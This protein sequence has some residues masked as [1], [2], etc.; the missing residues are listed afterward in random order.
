MSVGTEAS[1]SATLLDL[2]ET[3]AGQ[4]GNK[5][6]LRFLANGEDEQS[7]LTYA[8][9]DLR[10]RGFASRLVAFAAP[11]DRAVLVYPPGVEFLVAFFGCVYAGVIAVPVA[12]PFDGA[13]SARLFTVVRDS[14]P[15]CVLVD[16]A[17][18]ALVRAAAEGTDWLVASIDEGLEAGAA[19][20][21]RPSTRADHV[22]MLQYTSGSTRMPRGVMVTHANLLSNLAWLKAAMRLPT[23]PTIVSWLPAFHDMG[24]IGSLFQTLYNG[25]DCVLMSPLD[26]LA[27][28]LVWLR[29]IS[30][31][32]A[33]A[34]GSP[35][36]GY[37]LAARKVTADQ[38]DELDLRAWQMACVTAE[39]IR[40]AG[41]TRF[42][43]AF[44]PCGF[45]RESFYPCY[46]L[47]E[48]TLMVTGAEARTVPQELVVRESKLQLGVAAPCGAS[49]ADT[50]SLVA[51]GTARPG[52]RVAIVDPDTG[53]ERAAGH[54]GEIW[55]NG[56]NVARGYWG[57][58][59]ETR[60][61][62]EAHLEGDAGPFLRTGDLGFLRDG[63][64]YVTGRL[65][66]VLI[67]R[68]RNLYPHDIEWTAQAADPRVRAGCGAAFTVGEPDDPVIVLV[69]EISDATAAD[70]LADVVRRGVAEK[71]GHAVHL[72]L[73]Q[74]RTIPK[75]SSGKVQHSRCRQMYLDGELAVIWSPEA[76][77]AGNRPGTVPTMVT[78]EPDAARS[79]QP[80]PDLVTELVANAVALRPDRLD[81][82][83]PLNQLGL[84]SLRALEIKE[85]LVARLGIEM[86]LRELLSD[87]SVKELAQSLHE[88]H[89]KSADAQS[90]APPAPTTAGV[91]FALTDLQRAYCAGRGG[92]FDLGNV[93]SHVCLEFERPGLDTE[94]MQSAWRR[95]IGHYDALRVVVS[96]NG[97]QRIESHCPA[98][99]LT[100]NDLRGEDENGITAVLEAS[101]IQLSHQ[102]FPLD[103]WPPFEIRVFHLP[104]GRYRLQLSVDLL[105]VDAAS[106]LAL[107]GQWG[108]LYRDDTAELLPDAGYRLPIETRAASHESS[109]YRRSLSYW[110]DQAV[111]LPYAPRLPMS[112]AGR[113][114]DRES[115]ALPAQFVRHTGSLSRDK[116]ESFCR[117]AADAGL[118]PTAALLA[119]YAEVLATWAED[120][121]FTVS[122]TMRHG[123][124]GV[125]GDAL[126]GPFSDF[127]PTGIDW[128][129]AGSF[130]QRAQRLSG[131]LLDDL[132]HREIGGVRALRE[133]G[134][135]KDLSAAE[136]KAPV[137]FTP[138][139]Q[140]LSV[141]D[142]LGEPI[143]AV[144]QTPQVHLDNQSFLRDGGLAFHW[145]AIDDMFAPNVIDE[146]FAAY[147]RL[148]ERLS[149]DE[150]SWGQTE[151]L[152]LLPATQF[153]VRRTV[154]AT[155]RSFPQYRLEE[156]FLRQCRRDP[157]RVA[158]IGPA[159]SLT[160]R[161]VHDM[162]SGLA[163]WLQAQGTRSGDLVAIVTEKGWEQ[164]IAVLA[165][166]L[167]GA[168]YVPL[169]P[170]LPTA[171][172]AALLDECGA[173]VALTQMRLQARVAWPPQVRSVA[174]DA[175]EL[176]AL[177]APVLSPT[178]S[179]DDLCCVL[180]TS[181]TTGAPKGVQVHH[182][183][184]V[185]A[186]LDTNSEFGVGAAD[187]VLAVTDLHHDMSAYDIFGPLA[188]G[189][190][191]VIIE[192]KHRRDPMVWMEQM[193][194]HQVTIWNS[195]PASML[196]M[197]EQAESAD[198]PLPETLRLIILGGDWIPTDLPDRIRRRAK[199][200][201][202]VSVGGPT[203]TTLWNIRHPIG[204]VPEDCVS[205]PYG[206]PIANTHYYVV[207]DSLRDRPDW[208]P[209][210]LCSGGAGTSSGY[211][212]DPALTA[213]KFVLRPQNGERICRTG[214]FG[215]WLP[216]GTL[217]FLGRR[218]GQVQID[219]RR[220][221]LCEIEAIIGQHPQVRSGIVTFDPDGH[222]RRRLVAHVIPIEPNAE[223]AGELGTYLSAQLPPHMRPGHI[224]FID[225]LPLTRS[226]KV[227]RRALATAGAS[228]TQPPARTLDPDTTAAV[229]S[230]V[231]SVVG[232]GTVPLDGPLEDLGVG[233][234][235]MVRI[236]N[237]LEDQFGVRPD[238][239]T[240]FTASTI[241][242]LAQLAEPP[243]PGD[244]APGDR[245]V[246]HGDSNG[247]P[248]Y[249]IVKDPAAR[250]RFRDEQHGLRRDLHS[251]PRAQL[252]HPDAGPGELVARR[253]VRA[254]GQHE[255]TAT[256]LGALLA[257]LRNLDPAGPGRRHHYGSGGGTYSVQT[258]LHV[259]DHRVE[260]LAG[261]VYYYQPV[262][263]TLA[264]VSPELDVF[265]PD[266]HW[267]WNRDAAKQ[268]AFEI[269]LIAQLDAIG[270]LYGDRAVHFAT[271]EA[272]LMT[273][274]L[275]LAAPTCGLGLCQIG[276]MDYTN[277]RKVFGLNDSH[278]FLHAL[279]GGPT[280][281]S[282]DDPELAS[283]GTATTP[284]ET[285]SRSLD[286][287]GSSVNV[288]VLRDRAGL[289]AS[290][291]RGSP[292]GHN[293]SPGKRVL[294]TGA[295]GF[296]GGFLLRELLAAGQQV[297]CLVRA[298]DPAHAWQRLQRTADR[299]G[300]TWP[301]T[302]HMI[303][304]LPGD[305]SRPRLG[306]SQ[307]KFD[308]LADSL[309]A[310]YHCAAP[311][312]WV[313][314]YN[315][316]ESTVVGGAVEVLRLSTRHGIKPVHYI[317]SLAVFPFDG[318]ARGENHAALDHGQN[319]LG[320]YAQAKWTGER[321]MAEATDRGLPITIYRPPLISG[322]SRTGVFN[323]DSYF[324][325]MIKGCSELGEAPSLD[326]VVDVAPVDYVARALVQLA[327]EPAAAGRVYHLNNPS[328]I[329]YE[330]F[331]DW[332]RA[333]GYAMSTVPFAVWQQHLL[334]SAGGHGNAL[335]PLA[336]HLRWTSSATMTTASHD[337]EATSRALLPS[338]L[339][340]PPVADQLLGV[341]FQA[342]ENS[343]FLDPRR[344]AHTS[345]RLA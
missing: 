224:R 169:S 145:D 306:L 93:G 125:G 278:V 146:M 134:R 202:I 273:Q 157:D 258:Y 341:Y 77:D 264:L 297:V 40:A 203:E 230:I 98:W 333:R 140:D 46:G 178:L 88:R 276:D 209:G 227:D 33:F 60:E 247:S 124:T 166:L 5:T 13:T 332:I 245:P 42:A 244:V 188:V 212:N 283:A 45:Q 293:T 167:C 250:R 131:Q 106:L 75:T 3:R 104:A 71:C 334:G 165:T 39:P 4:L 174:V 138:V 335:H 17:L 298:D 282:D 89:L 322:H 156:L 38:R 199:E 294:L 187:R 91:D 92:D 270:P 342:F 97:T 223:P 191:V 316:L 183:G 340:C 109:A 58:R 272:G 217:E 292:R 26:F 280:V 235:E 315:A 228:I 339:R 268:C 37:E 286:Q 221:E 25:G 317:S 240:M 164:Y 121:R 116:W 274:L 266:R 14:Q 107:I 284:E 170:E 68:G 29:A 27:K 127:L 36:F 259:K 105:T 285:L 59:D 31:Y 148:L 281:P 271:I 195:V 314:S 144:T 291:Q 251:A 198:R 34:S 41:L 61:I 238:V 70:E 269:Y 23:G 233:S 311:V 206:R 154:N 175:F 99:D 225:Q 210:E 321:V 65:K 179:I 10:A 309:D 51:C 155:T 312:S 277:L 123:P 159:C 67:V 137:V 19:K 15:C 122:V 80:I 8:Q 161:D 81:L 319:L 173:T 87:C 49:G 115:D 296:L 163:S 267:W 73:V 16:A 120:P 304:A 243:S 201:A 62:F 208:V 151:P 6:C 232:C 57:R 234:L 52:E 43:E 126:I 216:D 207:D 262:D 249:T 214:D 257:P 128:C 20:W 22:A 261:G 229:A 180:Y 181:G 254:F 162:A 11:G 150:S 253:S 295:T 231:G 324:E 85:T 84:D 252:G 246:V 24:L 323:A 239:E 336:A 337:C 7:Q 192:P 265:T 310:I 64:L 205:I 215:R 79:P 171:R 72:V 241:T 103:A 129:P 327:A 237:A 83:V 160:Y 318:T 168:A 248:R 196:M 141:F 172:L 299:H 305:V 300:I 345:R 194:R 118:T 21:R 101:R 153:N 50:V 176:A 76:T 326:G 289:E 275:E 48:A 158:L 152:G 35:P 331:L 32:H 74:A 100:V 200:A 110:R 136:A 1:R 30:N 95:L 328:P 313:K 219:G 135:R 185:N 184:M 94:R 279:V 149:I 130:A 112:P 96:A 63:Q 12:P 197:V 301:G 338:G 102:V 288:T 190:A 193:T 56:P 303:T 302:E 189:G 82:D 53:T 260:H 54:V 218:D 143:C 18:D 108:K 69:N 114:S 343:G 117:L 47:A 226:G 222:G 177:P 119:A 256:T 9:L 147:E 344:S 307:N 111:S 133:F 329:G 213:A 28:P 186:I 139:L 2:M 263:H 290:I 308:E 330:Q 78:A 142:W 113:R 242:A 255:M 325:R 220:V 66:D 55:V 211:L 236:A 86:S 182:R 320:G 90:A 132:D 287:P 44:A 204:D